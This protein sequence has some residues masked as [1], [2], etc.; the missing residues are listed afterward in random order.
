MYV[1]IKTKIRFMSLLDLFNV[2]DKIFHK[3]VQFGTI[4]IKCD[5]HQ[6]FAH[7]HSDFPKCMC[8]IHT[9]YQKGTQIFLETIVVIP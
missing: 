3:I 2:I 4:K 5:E 6:H 7:L 8:V 9:V 1:N